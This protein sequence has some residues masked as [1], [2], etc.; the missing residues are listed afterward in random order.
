[1]I[2]VDDIAFPVFEHAALAIGSPSVDAQ[3]LGSATSRIRSKGGVFQ[4]ERDVPAGQLLKLSRDIHISTMS[5]VAGSKNLILPLIAVANAISIPPAPGPTAMAPVA[6]TP[7]GKLI[8]VDDAAFPVFEHA[9]LAI[10]RTCINAQGLHPS[11]VRIYPKSRITHA[12]CDVPASQFLKPLRY[13]HVS[14]GGAVAGF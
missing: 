4:T 3:S 5:A 12:E 11:W 7:A 9:V 6:P 10:S 8:A 14:L 13:V 2:A 1:M